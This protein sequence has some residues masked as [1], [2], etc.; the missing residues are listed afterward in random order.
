M[1]V[2]NIDDLTAA[3]PVIAAVT[4]LLSTMTDGRRAIAGQNFTNSVGMHMV[5]VEEG[6]FWIG[7]T[8]FTSAAYQ[9][10]LGESG[11]DDSPQ[12]GV[13]HQVA[14]MLFEELNKREKQETTTLG[15]GRRLRP[16]NFSYNLPSVKQWQLS[17]D[18]AGKLG[19]SGFSDELSEWTSN[20][21]DPGLATTNTVAFIT[22]TSSWSIVCRQNDV[23]EA[24]PPQTTGTNA[25]QG[26]KTPGS[27]VGT[28][29]YW[30]KSVGF[31]VILLP[32]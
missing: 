2:L 24:L 1:V 14:H 8:E 26:Q 17:R 12:E 6:G 13:S 21:N 22:P 19:A 27:G 18:H 9:A 23:V 29:K 25:K 3:D 4:N 10:V 30:T 5:W 32:E 31:R 28:L 16:A 7:R 15:L 20:K 11:G